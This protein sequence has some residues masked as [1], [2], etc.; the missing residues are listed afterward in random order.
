FQTDEFV[1]VDVGPEGSVVADDCLVSRRLD[2]IAAVQ[3]RNGKIEPLNLA[4][5]HCGLARVPEDWC[6]GAE[7]SSG[8]HGEIAGTD[9]A[10]CD[11]FRQ[12]SLLKPARSRPGEHLLAVHESN[13]EAKD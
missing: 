1:R 6:R 12:I 7:N 5:A 4:A 8:V 3:L 11:H 10:A 13:L 9:G 2:V